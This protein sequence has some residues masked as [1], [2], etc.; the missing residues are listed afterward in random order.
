[1][2]SKKKM[3]EAKPE[4]PTFFANGSFF[5]LFLA[6]AFYWVDLAFSDWHKKRNGLEGQQKETSF[7]QLTAG[8]NPNS[9]VD[10]N[11][12][13]MS[14][15]PAPGGA[16]LQQNISF[17]ASRKWFSNFMG[18]FVS[19]VGANKGH[20]GKYSIILANLSLIALLCIRW[21]ESGH[22]PLS[23]LY[24]SLMFLSWSCTSIHIFLILLWPP[25]SRR[26][27]IASKTSNS[28]MPLTQSN[29]ALEQNNTLNSF[30]SNSYLDVFQDQIREKLL[31][32][33]LAP[34]AL[35]LNAFATFSLP[36]EM[37]LAGPLVPAL[38]SNW[39]MMHVTVMIISYAALILGSLLSIVF[40]ICA[41]FFKST[42]G[43]FK[44][45]A[46]NLGFSTVD[47]SDSVAF[48]KKTNQ[49][50]ASVNKS[51]IGGLTLYNLDYLSYRIIGIG[52][53]F[54]TIGILSGAVWANEAWG[55]YWSW[56]PKETWALLTWLIFAIYLHTRLTKGWEGEKPALIASLGF[57]VVWI[58][59]LGVNL[60]GE[61]LHSY[62]F[63]A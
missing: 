50:T 28:K 62:G 19:T 8:Q 53:P 51:G 33:I 11:S 58:C 17:S 42:G 25:A 2:Y 15:D 13:I 23:N 24:E 32:A 21:K 5:F 48:N 54:L 52:F 18:F 60:L 1:M 7:D 4:L 49:K 16:M 29:K 20:F 9:L 22:F 55:S 41:L 38:Q 44:K 14:I 34:L 43:A 63:F 57:L 47:Q 6:M 40:V 45:S 10:S 12:L 30:D 36:K 37:Q 3:F 27:I 61:G 59:Y 26:F 46:I 31:G 39:L 35:F 56:D